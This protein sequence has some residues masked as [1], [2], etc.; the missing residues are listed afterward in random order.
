MV[1]LSLLVVPAHFPYADLVMSMSGSTGISLVL[2][3]KLGIRDKKVGPCLV[4]NSVMPS[5]QT[6]IPSLEITIG[7]WSADVLIIMSYSVDMEIVCLPVSVLCGLY[8]IFSVH[9][10]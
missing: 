5:A 1:S 6:T 4:K 2:N 8:F 7:N 3:A 9:D 10:L